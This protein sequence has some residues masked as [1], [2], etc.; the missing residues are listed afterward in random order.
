MISFMAFSQCDKEII[1]RVNLILREV[2]V[3]LRVFPQSSVHFVNHVGVHLPEIHCFH[4]CSVANDEGHCGRRIL[5]G[6]VGEKFFFSLIA[7]LNGPRCARLYWLQG[8]TRCKIR[9]RR[10]YPRRRSQ[11]RVRTRDDCFEL[12]TATC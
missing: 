8:S 5:A 9:G 10:G 7:T 2:N 11:H 6:V 4:V 3:R 12:W 1:P